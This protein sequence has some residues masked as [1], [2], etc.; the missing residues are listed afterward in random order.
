VAWTWRFLDEAQPHL[1][2]ARFA[3]DNPAYLVNRRV[4]PPC[5]QLCRRALS[6][7]C[8]GYPARCGDTSA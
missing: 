3:T 8:C 4:F 2:I 1:L 6:F 5:P 7:L